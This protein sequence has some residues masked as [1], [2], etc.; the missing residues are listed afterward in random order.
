[1]SNVVWD[2]GWTAARSAK[3]LSDH[4]DSNGAANRAYFAM[5]HGARAALAQARPDLGQVKR[6][7]TVIRHFGRYLVK[8]G[9]LDAELGRAI[10]LA[11]DLRTIADYEP[12]FV[13]ERDAREMIGYAEKFLQC[14]S[15]YSDQP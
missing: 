9:G 13:D 8:E 1:V 12:V 10:S 2:K 4:G 15:A 3:L 6:H 14:L 7:A 11:F 5:F